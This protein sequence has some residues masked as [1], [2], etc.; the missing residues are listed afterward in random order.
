MTERAN[1]LADIDNEVAFLRRLARIEDSDFQLSLDVRREVQSLRKLKENGGHS[2]AC[3]N[4]G[5][6]PSRVMLVQLPNGQ[7]KRYHS[8]G[9][10]IRGL[11][12]RRCDSC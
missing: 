2:L 10:E 3:G 4:C 11:I 1:L 12:A 8:G 5:T 9:R 7:G 6:E